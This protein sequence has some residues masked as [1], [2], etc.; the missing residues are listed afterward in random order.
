ME[1]RGEPIESKK[2]EFLVI[3]PLGDEEGYFDADIGRCGKL[4][5]AVLGKQ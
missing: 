4:S 3:K 2:K 5:S 1:E